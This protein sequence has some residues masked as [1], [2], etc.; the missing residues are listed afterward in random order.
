MDSAENRLIRVDLVSDVV[1]PWC[2]VGFKQ[3][4]EAL[5]RLDGEVA[6]DLYW[7]P[8][9]LNPLMPEE[10]QDLREHMQQK[11][12]STQAQSDAGRKRLSDL[13]DSL[14]FSFNFYEGMRI[15]NTFRAHQLIRWAE[16]QGKQSDMELALFE[17]YFSKEENVGD[18]ETL[19][20]VAE[21]VGLD[22]DE[23]RAALEEERF[24]DPV[25]EQQR[26]WLR[27]GIQAVPS[28]VLDRRFLIPGAQDPEVFVS[29]LER[30][31]SGEPG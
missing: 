30:I 28:F 13:G 29:A 23:A 8:F 31:T 14:G 10:G 17:S 7:H 21:R 12:G 2:V 4:E 19:A 24:A 15:Y 20:G 6:V 5:A 25:R 22:S 16:G 9:E 1:C 11:Y 26:F 27:Q 3:F 18:L